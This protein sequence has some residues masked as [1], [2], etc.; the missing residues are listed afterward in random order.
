MMEMGR[1]GKNPRNGNGISF[2]FL[3]LFHFVVVWGKVRG[4]LSLGDG[5]VSH[6]P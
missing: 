2:L 5:E 4:L 3:L 6:P 1:R